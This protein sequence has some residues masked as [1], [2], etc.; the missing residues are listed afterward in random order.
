MAQVL[1]G[2]R[3]LDFSRI[4]AGPFCGMAL[5]DFGAEVVRVEPPGG[6]LDRHFGPYGLDG[7]SLVPLCLNRNKQGITLNLRSTEG[8]ELLWRLVELVDVVIHNY[9]P[10]TPEAA[11]LSYE[12]LSAI[13]PRIIVASVT[14]YGTEGPYAD[15]PAV[16][17]ILQAESGA[18]SCTGF[19]GTPP[20]RSGASF[21]DV[22]T[23][24]ST[25]MGILLALRERDR[26]GRGQA[27]D[28]ALIDAGYAALG[29]YGI[30]A[31]AA[32]AGEPRKPIGN[33]SY[34]VYSDTL[35]TKDNA[36]VTVTIVGQGMWNSLLKACDREHLAED[37]RFRTD[38]DR[39]RNRE[40]LSVILADWF[41]ARTA[42]EITAEL[43]KAHVP[44]GRVNN[45]LDAPSHPQAKFRELVREMDHG[46]A[47]KVRVNGLVVRLSRTPG[48]I[49]TPAPPIGADNEA[50]YSGLLGLSQEQVAELRNQSVL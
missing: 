32:L 37:I 42:A 9:T 35:R 8:Q 14:A 7:T 13:N 3:V 1:Q 4:L 48:E 25:A 27:V 29:A 39:R 12:R 26:S 36:W 21:V 30:Y 5:A 11:L 18:M 2:I 45:T 20:T 16:D 22:L 31:E 17:N 15:R 24:M 34:W 6:A 38:L 46:P 19:P 40:E 44:C 43:A 10:G 33:H 28:A 50:V 47:G 23:G 41:I 49:R